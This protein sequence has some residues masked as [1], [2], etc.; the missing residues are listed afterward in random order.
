M[1]T[2][3]RNDA[4]ISPSFIDGLTLE[5]SVGH[6]DDPNPHEK[7]YDYNQTMQVLLKLLQRLY[8]T[9]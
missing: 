9:H 6:T 4:A 3:G 5:G 2:L 8:G 7:R 1:M